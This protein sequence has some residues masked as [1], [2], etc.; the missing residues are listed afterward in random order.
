MSE[1]RNE[2]RFVDVC[3]QNEIVVVGVAR[4]WTRI[5]EG[6]LRNLG[7]MTKLCVPSHT[8]L[9]PSV[10]QRVQILLVLQATV[11]NSMAA[12][13]DA[14]VERL[15]WEVYKVAWLVLTRSLW[16]GNFPDFVATG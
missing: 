14:V 5:H 1:N 13:G 4:H 10:T 8:I 15:R 7:A 9:L 2:S 11:Q 12:D 16:T 3:A 6:Q